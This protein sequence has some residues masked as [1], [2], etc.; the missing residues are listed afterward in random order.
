M[1]REPGR[2]E[3]DRHIGEHPLQSLK[4]GDRAP[5]LLA[6]LHEGYRLFKGALRNTESD[7]TG[8]DPLA[9]VGV[10]EIRKSATKATWRQHEHILLNRKILEDDLR[11]GD[12]A[13]PH[14]GLAL[15]DGQARS[16]CQSKEPA[17]ALLF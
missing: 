12:A 13:K 15:S 2:I 14:R 17:N 4:L 9:V 8:A 11:F 10:D 6:L 7:R 1:E 3:R 5:E 16:A